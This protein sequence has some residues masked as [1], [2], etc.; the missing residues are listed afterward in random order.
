MYIRV[1]ISTIYVYMYIYSST[2]TVD[3]HMGKVKSQISLLS[4]AHVHASSHCISIYSHLY[5]IIKLRAELYIFTLYNEGTIYTTR[6]F[7]SCE[8]DFWIF[9]MQTGEMGREEKWRGGKSRGRWNVYL[10]VG[11]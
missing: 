7:Y 4:T 9:G 2:C 5:I 6:Y 1:N 3:S 11:F 10:S 8:L